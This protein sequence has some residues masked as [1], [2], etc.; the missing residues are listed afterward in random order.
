MGEGQGQRDEWGKGRGREMNG[1]GDTQ[2]TQVFALYTAT[3]RNWM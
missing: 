2:H 1:G 3:D